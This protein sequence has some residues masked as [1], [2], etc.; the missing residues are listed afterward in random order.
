[1]DILTLGHWALDY[2]TDRMIGKGMIK[3]TKS[4]IKSL[5]ESLGQFEGRKVKLL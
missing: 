4:N 5:L 2:R 3:W 1:M